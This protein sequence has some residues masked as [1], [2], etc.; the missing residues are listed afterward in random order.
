MSL[1]TAC[2]R[3]LQLER[4]SFQLKLD[5][6][7]VLAD[8][9]PVARI[10]VERG[11]EVAVC[12]SVLLDENL[13]V[14][15][16]GSCQINSGMLGFVDNHVVAD[17]TDRSDFVRLY[18]S[19]E[20]P[21]SERA[22]IAD[23][24]ALDQALGGELGY[25]ICCITAVNQRGIVPGILDSL[26]LYSEC[27]LYD[28]FAW[29]AAH[30]FDAG[31][32]PHFPCSMHCRQTHLFAQKRLTILSAVDSRYQTQYW[33]KFVRLNTMAYPAEAAAYPRQPDALMGSYTPLL[34]VHRREL[35]R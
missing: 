35:V 5:I 11:A 25:P 29:P 18:I 32:I 27:G 12:A 2:K 13:E 33:R 23:E 14:T 8:I 21:R 10:I 24:S 4:S 16:G 3:I 28:P 30:L 7:D 34:P 9:R 31:L 6:I 17:P 26:G 1:E 22:R 19:K 20:R 15:V